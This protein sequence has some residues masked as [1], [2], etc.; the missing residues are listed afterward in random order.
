MSGPFGASQW[1]YDASS[2]FYPTVLEDSLKFNDDESQYLSWTPA[3]TGNLQ[4]WTWSA[5]VKRGT[6]GVAQIMFGTQADGSNIGHIS[7]Q[8]DDTIKV[9]NKASDTTGDEAKTVMVFRDASAWYHIVIAFDG[10]QSTQADRTTFYVNGVE[11]SRTT[12][13]SKSAGNGYINTAV[14]HTVGTRGQLLGAYFDGYLS[15][16]HF[17]DGQALD[18]SS[19]GEFKDSIWIPAKYSG[20]YGT[21]GFRL[22]F[23]NDDIVEGFNAVTYRGNGGTQSISGLGFEPDFVW[24]KDRSV[25]RGHVLEDV[26]RGAGKFLQSNTTAA[27]GTSST[28][29]Q[30]FDADG[31]TQ[32]SNAATNNTSE[33]Y[34]AWCWDAGSGSAA[35]NTDGSITSTVKANPDYG[36]SIV[37]HTGTGS[38][39]TVGHGLGVKPDLIIHKNRDTAHNWKVYHSALGATK[40]LELDQTTAAAT[41]SAPFNNTE[42][43]S[44][45]MTVNNNQNNQSGDSIVSYVFAEVAGYSS[46]GSYSG[47]GSSGNAITTG[48]RPAFVLLKRT[49]T[50]SDWYIIDNTRDTDTDKDSPLSP[51][52]TDV[53]TTI[54]GLR[55]SDTG[56]SFADASYNNSGG[57]WLYAAFADTRDAA[58]WRDTS[59]NN[60]NWTPNNLDYRDSLIDSPTNNFATLN[61]LIPTSSTTAE[62]NLKANLVPLNTAIIST[63]V[64]N[65]G[66]WYAEFMPTTIAGYALIGISSPSN[67]TWQGNSIVLQSHTG[68]L[69]DY[70]DWVASNSTLSTTYTV[71][72]VIGVALDLDGSTIEYFKNG[73]SIG[74]ATIALGTTNTDVSFILGMSSASATGHTYA[75]FGQDSTFAGNTTASGNQDDNGIGNFKYPVPSGFLALASSNLPTPM[76]IDGSEYFNAVTYTGTGTTNPVTVGFSPDFTWI[77]QRNTTR[78]HQLLDIVRGY[79]NNVLY[80]NLTHAEFVSTS[81][82]ID[83]RDADGFTVNTPAQVNQ[84]GGT[85]VAWNWKA[86]GAAVSNTAGSITS[87]VSAN[88]EA[89]FSIVSYTGNGTGGATVGHSLGVQPNMIIVKSRD[90][91]RDWRVYH[92]SLGATKTLDLNTTNAVQGPNSAYWNSTEPTSSVFSIGNV[93]T[94]NGSG[95]DYIAY[96]FANTDGYLKAGSYTGNGSTSNPP[97]VF[98]G[99]RPAWVLIKCSSSSST[100]WLLLD[101]KREGY[102]SAQDVLFPESTAAEETNAAKT[103]DFL[104]NGFKVAATANVSTNASG[105]SYIFLAFAENPFKYSNA[106]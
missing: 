49:S 52:K 31:F 100:N 44:T 76:I 97:F 81:A 1:M 43:T 103:V 6:L 90:N 59:G 9:N 17:I 99:F 63:F 68:N 35:S 57:E 4:T 73:S 91:A 54:D 8:A 12:V 7:F 94:V 74:S 98:T 95:E 101:N 33:T 36:F 10:A 37:T 67:T 48:F 45:V 105:G 55:F 69:L 18:A 80:T 25:A 23:E 46:F 89:G 19:F 85:Y 56:F 96:V 11:Q 38:T 14:Q 20:S 50:T 79:T 62:G 32:G 16:V 39:A 15:D 88:T 40:A 3:S 27:E 106:R 28:T 13:S 86:G 70:G 64:V 65:S 93:T 5:W 87:Q 72:D 53:E 102:N 66:K 51:N 34:V 84:S 77:K 82:R 58:F 2:G 60:N 21:N 30:S 78:D 24:I 22:T 71:N 42:P 41:T 92:S 104:S 75:N 29:T 47:T 61:P 26:V 83:S